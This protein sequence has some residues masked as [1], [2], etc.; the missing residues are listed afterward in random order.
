MMDEKNFQHFNRVRRENLKKDVNNCNL[1]DIK[2]ENS[3]NKSLD[4]L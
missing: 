2:T 4:S 1:N 3:Y